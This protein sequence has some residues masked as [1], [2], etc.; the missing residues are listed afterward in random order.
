MLGSVPESLLLFRAELLD[1]WKAAGVRPV[2]AASPDGDVQDAC[3]LRGISF[4]G[5]P[6]ERNGI[7]AAR[8]LQTMYALWRL[9]HSEKPEFVLAY[10]IKPVIWGGLVLRLM[11]GIRFYALIT[12]LGF[13]FQAG[14]R[15]SWLTGLVSSLYRLSLRRAEKVVFQ[16]EENLEEFVAR[17]CVERSKCERVFGSGVNLSHFAFKRIPEGPMVFLGIGRLLWA[18]G[19]REFVSAAKTVR[20]R[21]PDAR[22]QWLGGVDS[23]PDGIGIDT[24]MRWRDDGDL[25]YLGNVPDVRPYLEGCH[26]F[27]LPTSYPEGVPRSILEALATGRPILT[28]DMPGCRDTVNEGVNGFLLPE[29]DEAALAEKMIWFIENRFRLQE[30]GRASRMLAEERFDVRSVNAEMMRIMKLGQ[31]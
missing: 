28:S 25:E 1:A 18:K 6:V 17:G 27:V 23:S 21:Y 10:T 14:S 26:V 8:D 9:F 5:Y 4:R 20:F 19:L 11:P 29:A 3:T 15:R 22:F 16:N 12:G 7:N 30:M 24:V 13:A 2:A 31:P